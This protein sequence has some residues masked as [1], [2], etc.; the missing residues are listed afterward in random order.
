[1]SD[2]RIVAGTTR[3]R[4][5]L[6]AVGGSLVAAGVVLLVVAVVVPVSTIVRLPLVVVGLVALFTGLSRLL[7]AWRRR[8]VDLVLWLSITWLVVIGAAAILAPV[9]PLGEKSD[10]SKTILVEP[11]LPPFQ[12]SGHILGTNAYGLDMLARVV[13]GARA[14]LTISL[15]AVAISLVVGGAIGV[16]AGFYRRGIDSVIGVL[17]NALLAVPPLILLIVL[18]SMLDPGV[19]N[20]AFALS[21]LTIPTMVRLARANTIAY[22]QREFVLAARAIGAT[23]PRIMLRE[24]VP[25]VIPPM[26]SMAVVVISVLI[27]AEA[28][29]SFLGLGIRP[30]AATWGNMIA[31]AQAS[32]DVMKQHPFVLLVPATALFLTVFAFNLLGERAQSK[33]DP[34]GSKL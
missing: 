14:S 24:L 31:E 8:R 27:V 28:S 13:W 5:H 6:A 25:N 4:G 21:L 3:S 12:D 33:W 29:L 26:L 9:L 17:T 1:M 23:K 22:A 19:R 11:Y 2:P 16:I 32:D 30:P 7:W 34:R 18:A 20:I 10:V 15:M